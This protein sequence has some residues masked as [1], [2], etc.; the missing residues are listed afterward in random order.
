MRLTCA[1][2]NAVISGAINL[3]IKLVAERLVAGIAVKSVTW[4]SLK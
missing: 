4:I 1:L 3:W 2:I